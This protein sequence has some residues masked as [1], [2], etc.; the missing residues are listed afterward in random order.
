QEAASKVRP[1]D[2]TRRFFHCANLLGHC[3]MQ[4]GMPKLATRWYQRALE[5]PNLGTEEKLA[6]WY[7]LGVAAE[8]DNDF[9]AANRYFEQVYAED[10]D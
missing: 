8:A 6:L 10:V 7:E 2:G 9:E 4:N 1:D 5:T 3:F